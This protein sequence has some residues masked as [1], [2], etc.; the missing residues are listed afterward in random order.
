MLFHLMFRIAQQFNQLVWEIT[1][2]TARLHLSWLVFSIHCIIKLG[3]PQLLSV[4]MGRYCFIKSSSFSVRGITDLGKWWIDLP[5]L[6]I[7]KLGGYSFE[8]TT[9]FEMSNLTSIQSIDFGNSCFGSTRYGST[10]SF[11]LIGNGC[12]NEMNNRSSSITF[13]QT[14]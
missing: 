11:S 7:I 5:Q 2:F 12:N 9:S 6:V 1:V 3:L 4:T 13:S 10:L 8:Y 14:T